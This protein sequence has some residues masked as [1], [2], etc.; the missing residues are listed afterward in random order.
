MRWTLRRQAAAACLVF[1]I[2]FAWH[3]ACRPRALQIRARPT[4]QPSLPD[5]NRPLQG[6]TVILDPGHGGEDPGAV[7]AS[8]REASYT[9]RAAAEIGAAL[10]GQG[11]AVYF[12]VLSRTLAPAVAAGEPPLEFPADARLAINNAPIRVRHSPR[13]LWLRAA[14]ARRL[15]DADT[16]PDRARHVF[17]LSLHLDDASDPD[18]HGS[19]VCIDRRRAPPAFGLFLAR[20]LARDGLARTERTGDDTPG[21]S[22][23][24]LGVLN[25]DFN[26]VP[27]SALLEMTTL[28]NFDDALRAADPQWRAQMAARIAEA[29]LS[30]KPGPP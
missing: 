25:P 28:S 2:G 9:Y 11:A 18:I 17:F 8:G 12:T 7:S 13:G 15:W 24:K 1:G 29:I 3:G 10:R 14:L 27:Q 26:P 22:V 30:V 5:T 6:V 23:R 19:L 21:L 4:V 20:A 16:D